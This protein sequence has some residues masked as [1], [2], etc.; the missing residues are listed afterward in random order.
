MMRSLVALG[1]AAASA[2]ALPPPLPGYEVVPQLSDEFSGSVLDASKW[3][4]AAKVISWPGR[5]PGLFDPNNVVVGGGS[6]QLWARPAKRNA[7]WPAGFDNFTTAAVRSLHSVRGGYY[8]IRWRSG[9]SGISSSWWFHTNNGTAWTEIDVFETT[10][11]SNPGG[12][13]GNPDRCSTT[14]LRKCRTGCPAD[15]HGTCGPHKTPFK[16][17][18]PSCNLCPCNKQNTSCGGGDSNLV[19]PSHVHVFK[20]PGVPVAELPQHCDCKE[21]TAGKAP[22]SK[23]ATFQAKQPW[24]SGFHVASMNW[25]I[26]EATGLST[27]AIGVDGTIVNTI[28]SPC[29]IEEIAMDFDRETMPGWMAIPDPAS[30]PDKPFEVDYVRSYQLAA[31]D[32]R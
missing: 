19:L 6:L 23:P 4:T 29:L 13:P 20:L 5:A 17:G 15:E 8:E 31:S 7:S 12:D 9:S 18:G 10:G 30:L 28:T 32:A 11:T 3:S 1:L 25:T 27:I 26:D 16:P 21:G 14:P 22:C 24:S 2:S